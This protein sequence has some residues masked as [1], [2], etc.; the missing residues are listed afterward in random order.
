M[1]RAADVRVS[2]GCVHSRKRRCAQ[3]SRIGTQ[4]RRRLRLGNARLIE[5]L[6]L[7]L[8]GDRERRRHGAERVRKA[9]ASRHAGGDRHRPVDAGGDDPVHPF[10]LGELADRGLVLGGDDRATVG[11]LEPGRLRVTVAGH[12]EEAAAAC[13]AQEP[14]LCGACP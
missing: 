10:R 11:V 14:E 12:D 9:E 4:R 7:L 3:S 8:L 2:S 13:R 1:L 6:A 5:P